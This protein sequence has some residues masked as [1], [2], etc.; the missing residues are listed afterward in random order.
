VRVTILASGPSG[1]A[2]LIEVGAPQER[3][4]ARVLIDCGLQ[5]R[6]LG[7]RLE[8]SGGGAQLEDLTALAL[9][10][11]HADHASGARAL[12]GAGLPV[13]CTTGTAQALD[14]EGSRAIK[15][16]GE[17]GLGGLTLRPVAIPHDA[18]EPVAFI[19]S[20]PGG[21]VGIVLDCGHV[22]PQLL[23]AL[24]GC[25]ALVVEA[26]HEP[27]LLRAGPYP[28]ALKR[29]IAGDRGLLPNAQAAALCAQLS[30]SRHPPRLVVL[31]HLSVEN[32]RPALA[33]AA[34]EKAVPALHRP[35]VLIAPGD[36]PLGA[37]E[38]EAGK[39][40]TSAAGP[41]RQLSL[42]FPH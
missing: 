9:T 4:A 32:N 10:H 26:N 15:A 8:R 30:A 39:V 42:A 36:R 25:D 33:R 40:R 35:L 12:L 5:P 19:A 41:P 37:F 27:A 11:E 1:N 29:R 20:A 13:Y 18:A 16:G 23:A 28:A 22:T 24:E 2:I 17:L 38:L 3:R 6:R 21:K 14:L 31:A 7:Q 34:L